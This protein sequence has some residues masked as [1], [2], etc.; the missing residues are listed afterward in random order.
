MKMVTLEQELAALRL[1]LDIEKVRFEE[2]LTLELDLED[3]AC[4]AL[5]PSLLFNALVVLVALVVWWY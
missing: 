5:I 2:R 3:D 1:Y 4:H